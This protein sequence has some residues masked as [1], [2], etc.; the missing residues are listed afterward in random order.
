MLKIIGILR[1]IINT[2]RPYPTEKKKNTE[3][4]MSNYRIVYKQDSALVR[5]SEDGV[6]VAQKYGCG[7]C[8]SS[9]STTRSNS[10]GFNNSNLEN[11]PCRLTS[12]GTT[13]K[14]TP[15]SKKYT[16]CLL[17]FRKRIK[18]FLFRNIPETPTE[19]EHCSRLELLRGRLERWPHSFVQTGRH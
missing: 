15:T 9:S 3:F 18:R 16:D 2:I 12:P 8:P 14:R 19:Q 5:R 6:L 7:Y 10:G 17:V 1:W 13:S 11:G 4:S